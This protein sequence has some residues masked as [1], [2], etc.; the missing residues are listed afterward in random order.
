[1]STW[2]NLTVAATFLAFTAQIGTWLLWG[3]GELEVRLADAFRKDLVH[4]I[5]TAHANGACVPRHLV[6]QADN[7]LAD[8]LDF[9]TVSL[10]TSRCEEVGVAFH[11]AATI[12]DLGCDSGKCGDC[13]GYAQ[14]VRFN[15]PFVAAAYTHF[16]HED[17]YFATNAHWYVWVFGHWEDISPPA[18]GEH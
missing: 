7:P 3:H 1:V 15:T 18:Y 4:I 12:R 2:K 11:Q 16:F 5:N 17:V 14:Q 9:E 10:L 13:L 6:L 8:P